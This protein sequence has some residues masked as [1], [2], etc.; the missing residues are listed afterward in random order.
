[1]ALAHSFG[2][3]VASDAIHVSGVEAYLNCVVTTG[4]F[5]PRQRANS[6]VSAWSTALFLCFVVVLFDRR[7]VDAI[8]VNKAIGQ[9][10]VMAIWMSEQISVCMSS[11]VHL[12][13]LQVA[14]HLGRI[15]G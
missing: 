14:H 8:D 9:R 2:V 6:P 1:M 5:L 11:H 15:R 4:A 13:A 10:G 7:R 3:H 12:H